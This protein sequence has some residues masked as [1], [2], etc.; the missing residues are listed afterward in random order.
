MKQTNESEVFS[1]IFPSLH[2][3][4]SDS[5]VWSLGKRILRACLV[6]LP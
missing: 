4:G 3:G 1:S 5:M 6:E 2:L